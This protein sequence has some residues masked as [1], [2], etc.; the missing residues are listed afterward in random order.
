M[1]AEGHYP[2]Y[3]VLNLPHHSRNSS[4]I[5]QEST[6]ADSKNETCALVHAPERRT[7]QAIFDFPQYTTNNTL[8]VDVLTK[9]VEDCSSSC[10]TWF[11]GS[12]CFPNNFRECVS[13][14]IDKN[15]VFS[16]CRVTCVCPNA[17][18]CQFLHFKY[19]FDLSAINIRSALCEVTLVYGDVN[20]PHYG[21]GWTQ[22]WLLSVFTFITP[23]F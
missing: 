17:E 23:F 2:W 19:V 15:G 14:S 3:D 20:V 7:L 11:T 16:R 5:P 6:L 9:D 13:A 18:S 8:T 4:W 21:T 22:F 1:P 12:S 10:W